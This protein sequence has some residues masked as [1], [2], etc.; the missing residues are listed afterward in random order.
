[1]GEAGA[2]QVEVVIRVFPHFSPATPSPLFSVLL[3]VEL[4]DDLEELGVPGVQF[5]I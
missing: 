1:M 4:L 2:E 3:R 5:I